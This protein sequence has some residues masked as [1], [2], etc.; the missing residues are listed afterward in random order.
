MDVTE[1]GDAPEV[2]GGV[3]KSDA[4]LL[5]A[6]L[7]LGPNGPDEITY[8]T[9]ART[10]AGRALIK[11]IENISGRPRLLRKALDYQREM[12]AGKT[13]WEV[14]V[15]RYELKLDLPGAGLSNIPREGPLV[16]VANHPF[17]ILDGLAFGHIMAQTRRDF[18]ILANSVFVKAPEVEPH[19]LPIDFA[20]TREALQL[21]LATRKQALAYL[22]GGGCV[23]IFPGGTVSTG[24]RFYS[25]AF[26]PTWKTFTAKL[27]Q[28]SGATVVPIFFDGVNSR[29]FQVASHLSDNLRLALL[30]HEFDNRLK[31]P[32]RV[33]IGAP[34]PR[35]VIDRFRGDAK[36]LMNFLRSHTYSL[37]PNPISRRQ[38]GKEWD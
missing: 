3:S 13:F 19:I 16:I 28:T 6:A 32:V 9:A 38:I 15:E 36:G 25:G 10:R 24:A 21:N 37:S 4:A 27:I 30:I 26:D 1:N 5:S 11:A 31:R 22:K 20:E 12:A 8:A 23:G 34:L 14:M 35:A 29:L 18:K 2:P 7:K 33:V 17:G